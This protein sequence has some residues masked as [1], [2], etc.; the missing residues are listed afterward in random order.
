MFLYKKYIS[1]DNCVYEGGG[2]TEWWRPLQVS[3]RYAQT[4]ICFAETET[5]HRWARLANI[6]KVFVT[7]SEFMYKGSWMLLMLDVILCLLLC[8]H[9]LF[10]SSAQLKIDISPAPDSPHY[11]LSPELLHVKPYPDL[12]VRP[13]KE[14][15]EFPA[16]YVYTPHTTY[17]WGVTC[18]RHAHKHKLWVDI[19]H[20]VTACMA[21]CL[22]LT[23]L[24]IL[25]Q[26]FYLPSV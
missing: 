16:R 5:C 23:E 21:H 22:A 24:L 4:I 11:C 26:S 17:R 2:Q 19:G 1:I 3:G 7:L 8:V 15:L 10:C 13:T 6:V 18:Q 12:R 20:A 9:D 14:V 25:W